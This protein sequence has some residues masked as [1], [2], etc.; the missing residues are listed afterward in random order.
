[1]GRKECDSQ[2]FPGMRAVFRTYLH[3]ACEVMQ[4]VKEDL[5]PWRQEAPDAELCANFLYL[6]HPLVKI[7]QA[8]LGWGYAH[9]S[10]TEEREKL[11]GIEIAIEKDR[12]KERRERRE[13]ERCVLRHRWLRGCAASD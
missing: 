9:P 4:A 3:V 11:R 12:Q 13:R 1:M 5:G 8:N 7:V 2:I 6:V 10:A